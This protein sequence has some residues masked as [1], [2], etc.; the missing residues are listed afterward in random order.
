MQD[1]FDTAYEAFEAADLNEHVFDQKLREL[2]RPG[3]SGKVRVTAIARP[4]LD[5]KRLADAFVH[6]VRRQLDEEAA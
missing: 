1:A 2:L 4:E 6:R 3:T 5:S